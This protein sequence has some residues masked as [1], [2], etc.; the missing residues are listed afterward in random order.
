MGLLVGCGRK[1][2]PKP[3]A[4]TPNPAVATV[5]HVVSPAPLLRLP[6]QIELLSESLTNAFNLFADK[7]FIRDW[8]GFAEFLR[9]DFQGHDPFHLP[10]AKAQPLALGAEICERDV[11]QAP[12]LG[13]GAFL[14]S[15]EERIGAWRRLEESIWKVRNAE[16]E[17]AER[18]SWGRVEWAAHMV[19]VTVDQG[20]ELIE[21]EGFA[22]VDR[23]EGKGWQVTQLELTSATTTTGGR[24]LF[25]DVTRSA[26]VHHEGIRYGRPGNDSDGWNGIA[27]H[28]VN[29]DGLW[30]VFVPSPE[31]SFLYL[32]QPSG[33]FREAAEEAGLM[34]CHGG[35]GV[36]FFD[37]ENDGDM[38]L[39]VGQVGWRDIYQKGGGQSLQAYKN[40]GKGHFTEVTELMGLD[41][42]RCAAFGLTAFDADGDGYLDVY[43]CAYGRMGYIRNDSWS[44]ATNGEPDLLLRNIGG[45]RFEDQTKAAGIEERG[46][47]Y[48]SVAADFDEDGD[49]DLYVVTTFGSNHLWQNQGD[50][51]FVNVAEAKG[52]ALRGN[53]M[54]VSAGD[55]NEDG[56]LDLFLTNPSS[57][58][59]RRVLRRF[60]EDAHTETMDSLARMAGGNLLLEGDGRGGF[61]LKE[62]AGGAGGAGWAWGQVLADLD[63]DG[64]Q[65]V[66]CVN[67]FVT[68]D[69]PRD[70]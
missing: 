53:S 28:D 61:R 32:G 27:C 24:E 29:G 56:H 43:V 39:F 17:R 48:T 10:V 37:F 1:A 16:Y 52:V 14:A 18:P 45:T 67:G 63:L 31:R 11:K 51:T 69:I 30:D 65:D 55:P 60:E 34:E 35:T 36:L 49:Q 42:I 12:V 64:H 23:V 20:R 19:G 3:E 40:D 47:S 15:F 7:V 5:L 59:G 25:H 22:R 70:T 38:D 21:L 44:E 62:K 9:E 4:T 33:A 68:G 2:A 58:T 57:N 8:D 50:G 66:F 41:K 13:K 54:G 26:G 46:W 6:D